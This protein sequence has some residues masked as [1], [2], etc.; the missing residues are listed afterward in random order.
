MSVITYSDDLLDL[1]QR[2]W[3]DRQVR[4]IAKWLTEVGQHTEN[5][6]R[7]R[8]LIWQVQRETRPGRGHDMTATYIDSDI[9]AT[10][11]IDPYGNGSDARGAIDWQHNGSDDE[12][13]CRDCAACRAEDES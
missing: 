12:C 2:G 3:T 8:D 5:T 7:V 9:V 1:L 4:R 10:L 11:W 6:P 13:E